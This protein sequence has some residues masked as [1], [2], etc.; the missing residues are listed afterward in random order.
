LEITLDVS[1][2]SMS[3][4]DRPLH[5]QVEHSAAEGD[6]DRL[7]RQRALDRYRPEHLASAGWVTPPG[8]PLDGNDHGR[9]FFRS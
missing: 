7:G 6:R 5:P 1:L 4:V 8:E 3:G 9:E 2:P